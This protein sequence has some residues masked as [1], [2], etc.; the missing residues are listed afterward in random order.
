MLSADAAHEPNRAVWQ[1]AHE[2]VH[3]IAPNSGGPALVV[4]EGLASLFADEVA[5]EHNL[6]FQQDVPAYIEA[7]Q[8]TGEWLKQYPGAVCR[9]RKKQPSFQQ[10][11]PALLL[12]SCEGMTVELA[13]ALCQPFKK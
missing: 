3:L 5:A 12:S 10:W 9:I 7:A 8:S 6:G 2:S 1:L 4:E 11:S 13:S